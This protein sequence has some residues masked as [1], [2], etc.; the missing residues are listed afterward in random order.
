M[1]FVKALAV[2][3]LPE[4][5]GTT[6]CVEGRELALFHVD[7]AFYCIDNTCPHRDGPLGEGELEGEVVYCPWHAWQV[8]VKTGEVLYRPGLCV[9]TYACKVEGGTVWVEI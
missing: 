6:L 5:Q 9:R 2:E 3:D 4:G 8:N 7:G 1:G